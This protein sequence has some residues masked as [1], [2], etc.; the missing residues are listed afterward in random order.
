MSQ[1]QENAIQLVEAP[2]PEDPPE[3]IPLLPTWPVQA[4]VRK[5]GWKLRATIFLPAVL[6]CV[7]FWVFATDR[8]QSEATFVV[9][10]PGLGTVAEIAN[11]MQGTKVLASAEDSYI[12]HEYL[13][14]RD[15][16]RSLLTNGKLLEV[17]H[18]YGSDFLWAYPPVFT[19]SN[20]ERLYRQYRRFVD[21]SFDKTTGIS[22]LTVQAFNPEDASQFATALLASAEKMIN[23]LN[24][25][26]QRDTLRTAEEEVELARKTLIDDQK[27]LTEFRVRESVIDPGRFS[28]AVVMETVARLSFELAMVNAQ[29]AQL[30]KSAPRSVQIDTL[31][32]RGAALQEQITA[33]RQQFGA[34]PNGF[35]PLVDEYEKLTLQKEFSERLLKSALTS[36]DL[37]RVEANRQRLFLE[38]ISTPTVSDYPSAPLRSVWSLAALCLAFV[39][40]LLVRT[41]AED[42]AA[43][44]GP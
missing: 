37:S 44:V 8:Y 20:E 10:N 21:I 42:T 4:A 13:R 19:A 6:V 17:F 30:S 41:L 34:A 5:A 26:A 33:Q 27:R 23:R 14:S 22:T 18:G 40:Y 35:A 43:H 16:M 1:A 7:Y 32:Q 15:A 28:T 9:R 12:V 2:A 39:T 24:E 3:G 11:L 38:T 31:R 29:I 36:L 25:R